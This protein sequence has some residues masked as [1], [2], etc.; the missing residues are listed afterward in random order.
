MF[1]HKDA[2]IE[3]SICDFTCLQSLVSEKWKK[4]NLQDLLYVLVGTVQFGAYCW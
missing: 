4:D 2:K 3:A 1:L